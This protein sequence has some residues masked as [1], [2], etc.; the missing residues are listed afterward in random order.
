MTG[1]GLSLLQFADRVGLNLFALLTIGFA[2]H[3]ASGVVERDSFRGLR[4]RI[5]VAGAALA[6]FTV[7]RLAILVAQMGYGV[8]ILDPDI[9]PFAWMF[10]GDSTLAMLAGAVVSVGGVWF[11]SRIAAVLGAAMLSVGFGLTGHAQGL[12]EP[13]L[14]PVMVAAHVF[15]AGFWVAAPLSLYPSSTLDSAR[16]V[17][18]L[19]RFSTIAIVAIPVLTALG[20]WLSWILTEGGQKRLVTTYGL[21][22]LAKLAIGIIAMGLGALNKQIITAKVQA[23][24]ATG[25]KWLRVAL[26]CEATLFAAAIIAVS[27]ATT[28]GAP[29]G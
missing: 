17:S 1:D 20:V 25:Q 13:G 15:I 18:R 3:A 8:S 29:A 16:L 2:L 14:A 4:S 5:A 23:D 21:L 22:L 28:I 26:L 6:F 10:I 27:A 9:V 11:G 19:H 24:P 12:D 7:V